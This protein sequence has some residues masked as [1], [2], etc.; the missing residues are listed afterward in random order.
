MTSIHIV[1]DS[2]S[3][4]YGPY[5]ER[6]CAGVLDYTRKEGRYASLDVPEGANAGDSSKLRSYLSDCCELAQRWDVLVINCGLHDIKTDP[7]CGTRQVDEADYEKNLNAI[8]AL[9]A[10]LAKRT[11]WV[12]TT[13][14]VDAIHNERSKDFH[15]YAADQQHYNA[16]ADAVMAAAQVTVLD[17]ETF[18]RRCG[19]DEIFR[20]HVHFIDSVRELQ[21][22]WL[23][24]ALGSLLG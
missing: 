11:I 4:Q 23:A 7:A 16:I 22:A 18:T 15:R 5:L 2:I 6:Y 19:G 24:G 9:A 13:P 17:L 14:V 12:R 3:I 21:G 10:R 20:D 1:G 8:L